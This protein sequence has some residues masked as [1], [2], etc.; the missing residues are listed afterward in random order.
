MSFKKMQSGE[1]KQQEDV[2]D[3]ACS[4]S[5]G[6]FRYKPDRPKKVVRQ[7]ALSG[8][9]QKPLQSPASALS[10]ENQSASSDQPLLTS[11]SSDTL[12]TVGEILGSYGVVG[13]IKVLP[14]AQQKHG[15]SA[16]L[17]ADRWQIVRDGQM[18]T[19]EVLQVR[20]HNQDTLVA[21]IPGCMQREE[22]QALRG[23]TI[24]LYRSQFPKLEQGEYYWVDLIGLDAVTPQGVVLGKVVGL[25]ENSV[26]AVLRIAP[27]TPAGAG[28]TEENGAQK[29][30]PETATQTIP[31]GTKPS[32]SHKASKRAQPEI[33]VPF[34]SVFV[35]DICWKTRTIEVD[36]DLEDM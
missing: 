26:H 18:R 21:K 15:Q 36:W 2:P 11:S 33:L 32:K 29:S 5:L 34:V 6:A 3:V 25:L 31:S 4:P 28:E 30:A 14:Y 17:H 8:F 1:P 24:Q 35:G 12:I 7:Q 16:L 27:A 9:A 19:I 13:Q 10:L 23:W 20:A 22:A